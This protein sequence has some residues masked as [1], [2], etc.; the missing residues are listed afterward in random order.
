LHLKEKNQLTPNTKIELKILKKRSSIERSLSFIKKYNRVVVRKDKK[1]E[2][3]MGF[4]FLAML[5]TFY[6]K[7]LIDND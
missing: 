2:N 3:Y 5:D 4:V 7:V 6:K 1:I